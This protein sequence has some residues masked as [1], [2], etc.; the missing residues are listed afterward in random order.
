MAKGMIQRPVVG[1]DEEIR[2]N[3]NWFTDSGRGKIGC[4]SGAQLFKNQ[5]ED[6]SCFQEEQT[7]FGT[8]SQIYKYPKRR[9]HQ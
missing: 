1:A 3:L 5:L 8:Q 9:R 7:L 4:C 2:H 6:A